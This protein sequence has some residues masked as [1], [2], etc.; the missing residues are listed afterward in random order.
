MFEL[1][2]TDVVYSVYRSDLAELGA[3]DGRPA[4]GLPQDNDD[5]LSRRDAG[6]EFLDVT[7]KLRVER[8]DSRTH[9][10]HER[11][12]D[13]YRLTNISPDIVDT[14]LL[15][16]VQG[17]ADRLEVVNAAGFTRHGSGAACRAALRQPDRRRRAVLRRRAARGVDRPARPP[18]ASAPRGHRALFGAAVPR[19]VEEHRHDRAGARRRL[20]ARRQRAACRR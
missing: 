1:G 2:A 12:E 4:S 20:R 10:G 3:I 9:D 14:H 13:V 17:L 6:L 18:A 8:T 7:A 16:V 15:V 19:R 11:R 5:A